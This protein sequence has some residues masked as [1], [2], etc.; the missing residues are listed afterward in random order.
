MEFCHSLPLPSEGYAA[1][2]RRAEY[3]L[4]NTFR[5]ASVR[6]GHRRVAAGHHNYDREGPT[7]DNDP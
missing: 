5:L 4:T 1:L 7:E 3:K 2:A 6:N